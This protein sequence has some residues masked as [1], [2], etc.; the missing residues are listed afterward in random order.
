MQADREPD[1]SPHSDGKDGKKIEDVL[2]KPAN[3]ST[4]ARLHAFLEA[5]AKTGRVTLAC[6][7]AHIA[8]NTHYRRLGSDPVY[9][10][11]FAQAEQQVG[12]MLEDTAVERALDG[13]NHLLLALLKRFRPQL[14]REHVTAEV[15]GSI[16]LVE[17]MQAARQRVFDMRKADASSAVG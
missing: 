11:A 13:D 6:E 16:E 7:A 3:K 2:S 14:Y 1:S 12:Q 4:P 17:R 15:S 9:R 8:H 5:Y 10:A